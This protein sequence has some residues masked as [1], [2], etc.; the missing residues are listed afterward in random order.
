MNIIVA[1]SIANAGSSTGQRPNAQPIME[2]VWLK[3]ITQLR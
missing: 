1:L 3:Y 2:V